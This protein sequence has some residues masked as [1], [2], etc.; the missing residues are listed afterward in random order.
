MSAT[1]FAITLPDGRELHAQSEG[2]PE[3]MLVVM[4]HGSPGAAVPFPTFDRAASDR[5]IRLVTYSR[6]GFGGSSRHE[7]RRVVDCAPDV[8]ALADH[9]GAERF[10]TV[11][12]SGGGPHALACAARLPDRVLAAATIAGVAPYD[13]EGLD[14]TADM[15]EDNQVEYP[16]AATDPEAHLAWMRPH[17][18][19]L[20]VVTPA[21]IVE[22]LR[23]IISEV[24]EVSLS[25]ALGEFEAASFRAA[26][27]DGLWGW[28]DDDLAFVAPWGFD[29]AEIRVPVTIWQGEH[30]LMVPPAHGRWLVE[31]VPTARSGLRPEH[32][33]LSLAVGA[34]GDIFDDLLGSGGIAPTPDP[35]LD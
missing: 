23:S 3:G 22:S 7:G 33:H 32:G 30:D 10:L 15:G 27:R 11:G 16:L 29:L 26:F 31:H 35:R 2:D 1:P 17:A 9:L 19:A 13:A 34:V 5:R 25:G 14:W 21:G 18:E 20:A 24:D 28:R 8:A 6:P 4:H 12:W